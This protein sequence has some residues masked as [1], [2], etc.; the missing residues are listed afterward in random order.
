[1]NEETGFLLTMESLDI[2][3]KCELHFY[4]SGRL[5]PFKIV[6]N[7]H[8]PL[9][10][11]NRSVSP[12]LTSKYERRELDL[13]DFKDNPVDGLYFTSLDSFF[14]G[15]RELQD[16]HITLFESDIRAEDRFLMERHINGSVHIK[17]ESYKQGSLNVFINPVIS[18]CDY[19]PPRLKWLSLDIETGTD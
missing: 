17:G 6:Y 19:R 13:N 2:K 7:S 3:G 15:K 1:M 14:K 5:G 12:G 8:K 18:R 11:I 4:G 9:F 10:F 16:K